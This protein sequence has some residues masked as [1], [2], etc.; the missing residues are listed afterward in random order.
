[1]PTLLHSDL[2]M[3]RHDHRD[4]A[5]D[6]GDIDFAHAGAEYGFAK[7][8]INAAHHGEHTEILRHAP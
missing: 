6:A 4:P 3:G 8:E 1:M 7:F 2:Q 5:H